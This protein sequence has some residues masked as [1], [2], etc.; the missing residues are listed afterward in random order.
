MQVDERFM[1][2]A[3]DLAERGRYSVSPN[4]MVGCVI[5]RDGRVIGEGFHERAGLA[6]AEVAALAGCTEDPAGATVYVTLEP[7][8]HTGRTPPCADAVIASGVRRV[9]VAIEDPNEKVGGAGIARI[10]AAGIDVDTGILRERATRINEAFLHSAAAKRPF[11]VMKA[12]ITLDAKLATTGGKSQWI[13]SAEARERALLLREEYDAILAGGGT[14]AADNPHLTR[15]LGRNGS[16]QPWQRIIVD[17]TGNLPARSNVFTDGTRT[18][19]FTSHPDAYRLP[20]SV[21]VVAAEA[22]DGRLDLGAV[23]DAANARGIRSILAEG[24][25]LVHSDLIRRRLWQ[26]MVLFV[27]PMLVGGADAPSLL[28][29]AGVLNL[30]DAYRFHFDAVERV[31]RD[32][33]ITAY[34]LET[35]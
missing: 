11:V 1:Q 20:A 14:V 13:T 5:V 3:L 23:L 33:M 31:G 21:E 19:L 16:I 7:C 8:S 9:V 28:A 17:A 2:R 32:L 35:D 4:P 10:R 34:P 30:T 24:G 22:R 29:G 6:H 18:I 15:R 12:G 25:S 27:A 26:K